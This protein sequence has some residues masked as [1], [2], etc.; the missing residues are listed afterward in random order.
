MQTTSD[1][2]LRFAGVLGH[3]AGHRLRCFDPDPI[4]REI[5]RAGVNRQT[6][7]DLAW[8][9]GGS[10]TVEEVGGL[11]HHF[12]FHTPVVAL[13]FHPAS[14]EIVEETLTTVYHG[15]H[16]DSC[17]QCAD[18]AATIECFFDDRSGIDLGALLLELAEHLVVRG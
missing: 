13:L 14:D 4:A 5:E 18:L 1:L 2:T 11:C 17:D 16:P 3:R 8:G 15:L 9:L 12:G 6:A 7:H 10:L